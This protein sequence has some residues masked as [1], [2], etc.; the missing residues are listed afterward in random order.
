M[1]DGLKSEEKGSVMRIPVLAAA[2]ALALLLG[3]CGGDPDP[4][5]QQAFGFVC[6]NHDT[7]GTNA[8]C[9]TRAPEPETVS[10]FCYDTLGDPNCFDQPDE[11]SKNQE[12]GSSGK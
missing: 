9:K 4:V 12:L 11:I 1:K 6:S 8:A 5:W 10:R 2:S 7:P 3:S